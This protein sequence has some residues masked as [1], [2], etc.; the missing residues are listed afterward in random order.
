MVEVNKDTRTLKYDWIVATPL[1]IKYHVTVQFD[2]QN[3]FY[4]R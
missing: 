3:R 4:Y 2:E 1:H